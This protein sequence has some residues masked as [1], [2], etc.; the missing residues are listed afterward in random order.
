MVLAVLVA[1]LLVR[2]VALTPT[3]VVSGSME[4]TV[5]QGATVLVDRVSLRV[6]GLR[7]GDLV[8]FSEP[9]T[10]DPTLKR[11]VGLPGDVVAI[12]DAVTLV[13]DEPVAEP[14]VDRDTID[15]LYYGPVGVPAGHVLLL[16]DHRE[17]SID[18]RDYGPVP[19]EDVTGRVLFGWS[20]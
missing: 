15:G 17:G 8:T 6:T 10:G 12:E 2:A 5:A 19:L 20:W 7:H 1:V 3:T 9:G 4:P 11:V 13:D 16:G 18:S 14:Y